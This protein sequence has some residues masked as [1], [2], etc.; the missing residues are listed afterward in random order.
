MANNKPETGKQESG[1]Q[2]P[3]AFPGAAE[4][5]KPLSEVPAKSTQDILN[6]AARRLH[7]QANFLQSL[8]GCQDPVEAWTRH[9]EYFRS[10][11]EEYTREGP[12][13][14]QKIQESVTSIRPPA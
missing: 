12:K 5:L 8:A 3:T 2:F 14:F 7:A 11:L 6:F 4:W 13:L 10:L 9:A 1:P